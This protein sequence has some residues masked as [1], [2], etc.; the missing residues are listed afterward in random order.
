MNTSFIYTSANFSEHG[1]HHAH[2]G[3]HSSLN[4]GDQPNTGGADASVATPHPYYVHMAQHWLLLDALLGGTLTMRHMGEAFL[5][6]EEKESS[7]AYRNRLTRTFL[8]P[9]F[10]RGIENIVSRPFSREVSIKE[11]DKF[12]EVLQKVI[13]DVDG[14]G[15]TFTQLAAEVFWDANVYGLGHVLIDMPQMPI[16]ATLADEKNV[17]PVLLRVDPHDLFAWNT[18]ENGVVN[19]VQI[20][21]V[22][23]KQTGDWGVRLVRRIKVI[24]P[25]R[26]AIYEKGER[27]GRNRTVNFT[28]A[29]SGALRRAG[30]SPL[31]F[32]PLST[33]YTNQQD[34][35][36]AEPP[37]QGLADINL[38]HWQSSSDQR[39][40][41]HHARVPILFA[42]G[43]GT[44]DTKAVIISSNAVVRAKDPES[45]LA[46]VEHSGAAIDSGRDDLAALETSMQRLGA[47]PLIPNRTGDVKATEVAINEAGSQSRVQKWVTDQEAMLEDVIRKT[48][49]WL[50]VENRLPEGWQVDIFQ[51]FNVAADPNDVITLST[52]EERGQ[53]T[54]PTLLNEARRRG[55]LSESLDIQAEVTELE[56]QAAEN[57]PDTEPNEDDDNDADPAGNGEEN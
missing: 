55:M 23:E 8:E 33:L 30:R 54:K 32:V 56:K 31:G 9:G 36:W 17:R 7:K 35:M 38:A 47:E 10:R 52:M 12:P 2:L 41:V 5:P 1:F 20:S 53:I 48:A 22:V 4:F 28:V 14:K 45:R 44:D 26:F 29:D 11:Y 15:K 16:E 24:W 39:N 57:A 46:Y 18:D 25:D 6:R 40:I 49:R 43:F 42:S 19:R 13:D 34:V 21:E 37:H 3:Q 50:G 27:E 51:D